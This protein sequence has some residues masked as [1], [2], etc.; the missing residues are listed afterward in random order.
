MKPLSNLTSEETLQ[1]A[2]QVGIIDYTSIV[3]NVEEMQRK[4]ILEQHP[5]AIWQNPKGFW[6]TNFLDDNGKRVRHKRKDRKELEDLIVNYYQQK[7]EEIYIN[8][9]FN[10]WISKKLEY[11]EIKKQSYDRYLTDY[12]RFFTKNYSICAKKFKNIS[13]ADLEDFIKCTIR[14]KKL[15]Q[16]TYAGLR[17]LIR[18]IFKYGK[19]KGY[20]DLSMTEFFGD[21][22]LPKSIFAKKKICKENE[23]FMEDEIPVIVNYLK[24]HIDIWNMGILLQFQTGMRVGEISALRP[25]DIKDRCINICRTEVKYRDES[26]K[27]TVKVEE[28]PKTEAG[29]RDLIIPESAFW[30][31]VQIQKLNPHGEYLFMNKG[32]RIREN[33]FNKRVAIICDQLGI[34]RRSSHKIRRAYGTTLIDND[35]ADSIISEQMGHTDVTTTR[36]LYYFSNKRRETKIKQINDAIQI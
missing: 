29:N 2:V 30:T 21:L 32:K 20:T 15:T 18:G 27:W 24:T 26:E 13:D 17:T 25:E 36:K 3:Q 5:Y 11:G 7:K 23:I 33:T 34:Q 6:M 14:D 16:K 12:T 35:V 1:F 4:E 9:V 19:S 8:D 28:Y 10:E 22:Q 31:L